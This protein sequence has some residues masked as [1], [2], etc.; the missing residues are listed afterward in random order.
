[1]QMSQTQSTHSRSLHS[2]EMGRK[3]N[4]IKKKKWTWALRETNCFWSTEKG[5]RTSVWIGEDVTRAMLLEQDL[6]GP[7]GILRQTSL[8]KQSKLGKG[9][10]G[11]TQESI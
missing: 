3:D 5:E 11:K 8:G 4:C 6:K 10:K 7:L 9:E 1:M 2:E